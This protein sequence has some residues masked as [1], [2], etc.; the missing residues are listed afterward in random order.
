MEGKK[1]CMG[2][3]NEKTVIL[4]FWQMSIVAPKSSKMSARA[5]AGI[6]RQFA[7]AARFQRYTY[8]SYITPSVRVP[9]MA[10]KMWRNHDQFYQNLKEL[11]SV[12]PLTTK[13]MRTLVNRLHCA[14]VES[15]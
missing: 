4:E 13:S 3:R 2:S 8:T 6:P 14:E 10:P 1:R 5:F 7:K 9:Q 11:N 15:N 12:T